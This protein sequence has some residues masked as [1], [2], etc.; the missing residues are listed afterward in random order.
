MRVRCNALL[1]NLQ[2]IHRK[3]ERAEAEELQMST[4][5]QESEAVRRH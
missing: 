5:S 4:E 2:R 1:R 3:S